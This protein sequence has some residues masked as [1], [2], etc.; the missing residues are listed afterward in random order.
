MA[1]RTQRLIQAA[2]RPVPEGTYVVGAGL[3]VAGVTTYLFQI[4]SFRSLSKADY[5]ALNALWVSVFVLA[6]GFFLP[7]EQEVGRA[8][9]ARRSHGIGGGPIVRR[10]AVLGT[11]LTIGL[12]LG[13]VVIALTTNV[14]DK[15]FEGS[16]G[17]VACLVIALFSY[18]FTYLAR[19]TVAGNGR[20]RPYSKIVGAEGLV[21][22]FPRRPSRLRA[23]PTPSRTACASRSHRRSAPSGRCGASTGSHRPARR[24]RGRSSRRTSGTCSAVR[25][26]LRR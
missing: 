18:C 10:A 14:I 19:G 6:P 13:V 15:L 8:V 26:W 4:L 24:H 23:C 7:L 16:A 1:Q 5:A 3:L 11:W 9:A 2:R 21:R 22:V 20:F 17:L 25:S 12:G